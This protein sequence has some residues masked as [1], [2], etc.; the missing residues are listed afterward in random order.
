MPCQHLLAS[1]PFHCIVAVIQ[2]KDFIQ[3]PIFLFT[4]GFYAWLSAQSQ[5]LSIFKSLSWVYQSARKPNPAGGLQDT[6]CLT[7]KLLLGLRVGNSMLRWPFSCALACLIIASLEGSM[8]YSLFPHTVSMAAIVKLWGDGPQALVRESRCY[9]ER[10]VNRTARK[11]GGGGKS[12]TPS[13]C[14][15]PP[16]RSERQVGVWLVSRHSRPPCPLAQMLHNVTLPSRAARHFT[17]S[18][19]RAM[20]RRGMEMRCA[21]A[22]QR[23]EEERKEG[24]TLCWRQLGEP[25]PSGDG[26]QT[27]GLSKGTGKKNSLQERL[28]DNRQK[29]KKRVSLGF[30]CHYASA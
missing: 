27:W 22:S 7:Q 2:E 24:D 19:R 6:S 23:E 10:D 4:K 3:L 5:S 13:L 14:P 8:F 25:M 12:H 26:D 11:K 17:R 28:T 30:Q 16:P 1:Y 20:G 21:W 15:L 29:R 9:S 18:R